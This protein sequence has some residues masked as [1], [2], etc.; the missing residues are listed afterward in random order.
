MK[1]LVNRLV[2]QNQF[3][4]AEA[5]RSLNNYLELMKRYEGTD[6]T[7]V[8]KYLRGFNAKLDILLNDGVIKETAYSALKEDVYYL[9]GDLAHNKKVEAPR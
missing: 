4:N 1:T 9:I 7:Q 8:D 6:A 3:T 5:P 2:E